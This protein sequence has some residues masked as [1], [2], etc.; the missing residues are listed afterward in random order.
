VNSV[1]IQLL[2]QYVL[3]DEALLVK[4]VTTVQGPDPYSDS[5]N[6][7]YTQVVFSGKVRDPNRESDIQEWLTEFERTMTKEPGLTEFGIDTGDTPPIVQRPYN[8]P[9]PE[10]RYSVLEL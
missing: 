10:Q 6:Q 9:H 4:R 5:M 1:H 3:R 2:K 7:Q 8:T